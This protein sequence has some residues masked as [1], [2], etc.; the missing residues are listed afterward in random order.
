MRG[1]FVRMYWKLMGNLCYN[2][3]IC[4]FWKID[5]WRDCKTV[6]SGI[7]VGLLN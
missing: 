5:D 1:V 2:A 6:F 3:K 7:F 4:F